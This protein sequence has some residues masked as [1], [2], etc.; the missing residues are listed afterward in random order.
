MPTFHVQNQTGCNVLVKLL[1]YLEEMVKSGRK[2]RKGDRSKAIGIVRVS[3]AKQDIGAAAQRSELEKWAKLEGVELLCIFEDLGVS[4][5]API[6]ERPGLLAGI[7][8]LRDA[9]AGSLVAV[10]RDR[11]ARHRHTIADVERAA[12][13]AGGVLITT[14]GVCTGDD[15][16][17]EEVNTS[18]H[19]LMAALELRKI[20]TR[21][22]SRARTCIAQGR[23]H[24]GK[25]PYG[26]QRKSSGITGRS[27]VVVELEPN[28]D[29]QKVVARMCELRKGGC[30]LRK[31]AETLV[32]E[33]YTTRTGKL[34]Q[35]MVVKRVLDRIV[36]N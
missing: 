28:P 24:G 25:L 2:T 27:G 1:Q 35:A 6:T 32:D 13:R 20:R 15:S 33:G 8:A 18:I 22:R 31:I 14:D 7:S 26:Y 3:T 23:T 10:K 34:W 12:I 16:E 36:A 4:G 5:A 19:D 29:E 17:S 30:S 11:F 21:N 9:G